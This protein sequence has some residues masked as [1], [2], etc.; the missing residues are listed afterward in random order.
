MQ[1]EGTLPFLDYDEG[2]HRPKVRWPLERLVS[3]KHVDVPVMGCVVGIHSIRLPSRSR[4]KPQRVR[5]MSK[6]TVETNARLDKSANS[7]SLDSERDERY[8]PLNSGAGLLNFF[9]QMN[10]AVMVLYQF[11]R[12]DEPL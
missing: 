3:L 11:L 5:P 1:L 4:R 12:A 2:T 9:G 10:G 7:K 6:V 8:S